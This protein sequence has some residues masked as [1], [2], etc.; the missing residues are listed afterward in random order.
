LEELNNAIPNEL[1]LER[2]ISNLKSIWSNIKDKIPNIID[3]SDKTI[4]FGIMKLPKNKRPQEKTLRKIYLFV[5]GDTATL[6]SIINNLKSRNMT[7]V[8]TS[9]EK[10]KESS[11]A[12][13]ISQLTE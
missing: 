12:D 10:K 13:I 2:K 4:L 8:W 7:L 1:S 9:D 5:T 6:V 3:E 11:I